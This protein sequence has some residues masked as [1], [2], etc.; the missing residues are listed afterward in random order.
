MKI[1]LFFPGCHRRGGIERAVLETA[2]FLAGRGHE[3]HLCAREWDQ[4]ELD[5]RVVRHPVPPGR[6]PNPLPAISF[7]RHS[8]RIAGAIKPDVRAC[9]GVHCPTNCVFWA[10]SVH[11]AWLQTSQSQRNLLGRVKQ[12][13]NPFHPVM[14]SYEKHLLGKRRYRKV[15][16][17]TPQVKADMMRLYNV[18]A[19]DIVIIP[20]GYSPSEFNVTERA[21]RRREIRARL[22]FPETGKI[23]LFVA[24][25]LERKGFGPLLT[26]FAQVARPDERLVAV[27]RFAPG[28]YP[29]K[30]RSLGLADRVIFAGPS[31]NVADFYAAADLFALPTQYEPWG[32]VIIEAMASGLPVLTSR[33]AGA[34]CAVSDESGLLLDDPG[35]VPDIA[36]KMRRLLDGQHDAAKISAS[37]APF[38]WN[39]V[40]AE[41]EQVLINSCE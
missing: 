26:A 38:A 35:D 36:S 25:E 19:E 9:F 6:G 3:V 4:N 31:K 15:I 1:A 21:Q 23:V 2:N 40:L 11:R 30:A 22:E 27:G 8:R 32:L 41:Y 12:R 17:Y 7:A 28:R 14:L 18:P 24:N 29:E 33:L 37:V 5:P 34:A 13:L 16:A 39:R 10:G 20:N